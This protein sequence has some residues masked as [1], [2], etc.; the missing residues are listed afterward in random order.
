MERL[1]EMRERLRQRRSARLA[2]REYARNGWQSPWIRRN[3]LRT[4]LLGRD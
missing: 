1:E 4:L 3:R 2:F